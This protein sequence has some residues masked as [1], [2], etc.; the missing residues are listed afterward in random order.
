MLIRI[1]EGKGRKDRNGMLSPQLLEL[2]RLWWR[3][4]NW[5]SVLLPHGWL[6]PGRSHIDPIFDMPSGP[7]SAE[8]SLMASLPPR[9]LVSAPGPYPDRQQASSATV[10]T[11]GRRLATAS[12]LVGNLIIH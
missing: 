12:D 3:E 4:G 1:E 8:R 11:E 6:S 2:L 10:R 7:R 5:R 9:G